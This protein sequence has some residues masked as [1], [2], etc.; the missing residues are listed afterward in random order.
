MD[1][2]HWLLPFFFSDDFWGH[3]VFRP[4]RLLSATGVPMRL[5]GAFWGIAFL[6]LGSACVQTRLPPEVAGC[7]PL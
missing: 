3:Y 2:L 6:L 1:S 7:F 4:G 5:M